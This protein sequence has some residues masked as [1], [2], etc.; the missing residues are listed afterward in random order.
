VNARIGRKV[1]ITGMIGNCGGREVFVGFASASL[2]HRLSF[3]D[4]LVEAKKEGYQRRFSEAHSLE[5][6]KY[7]RTAGATTIPLTFNLRPPE[8]DRWLLSRKRGRAAELQIEP[9][10]KVLSQ[11][12]CQHR[13]GFLG[14]QDIEL[15]FMAFVGLTA[16]EEMEIFNRINAKAKGLSSSLLDFHESRLSSDLARSNPALLIALYLNDT[17]R[18]P[19]YQSLDIGG[20]PTVG[21]LRR[22]SLRT[23][24]RAARRFLRECGGQEADVLRLCEAAL[25]FWVAVSQVLSEEWKNPRGFLITK[26][27]GVY[28]LMS[29]AGDLVR[30]ALLKGITPD[31][32]YFVGALSDFAASIDW[33]NNG[34]MKGFGGGA[35]ADKATGLLRAARKPTHLRMVSRG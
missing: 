24:Q 29:I 25:E 33:S 30:E 10:A 13:L 28:G 20:E 14:D 22:A 16:V 6:R 9:D 4:V 23:M 26:G 11:V 19:W 32:K 27:I 5:F 17:E 12:D 31:A 15:A 34:P 18:S 35:G 8:A 7:I 1:R 3:A 21:M 2:L